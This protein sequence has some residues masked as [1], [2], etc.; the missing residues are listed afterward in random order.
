ME[1]GMEP[2]SP[3]TVIDYAEEFLPQT[4]AIFDDIKDRPLDQVFAEEKMLVNNYQKKEK[5]APKAAKREIKIYL[6]PKE[7][8]RIEEHAKKHRL[9]LSRY[10]KNMALDG[11]IYKIDSPEMSEFFAE[12]REAKIILR[13]ILLAFYQSGNYKPADLESIQNMVDLINEQQEALSEAYRE[14]TEAVIKLLPK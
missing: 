7:Y 6:A 13:K 9:S 11:K 8:E 1:R 5:A 2:L 4:A 14:N 10:S 12:I 3:Q